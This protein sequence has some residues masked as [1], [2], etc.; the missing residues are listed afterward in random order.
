MSYLSVLTLSQAK[1][2]LRVDDDLNEDDADITNMINAAFSYLE[3]QT[4]HM[5]I[6]REKTYPLSGKDCLTIHDHPVN[7][8]SKGIDKDDADVAITAD[9]YTIYTKTLHKII[10]VHDSDV[11]QLV[12]NV[13]Y[14]DPN[15]IPRELVD[16]GKAIIK[17][18]YYNK[19]AETIDEVLTPVIRAMIDSNRRFLI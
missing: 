16:A 5:F 18:L 6:V 8:V 14:A 1:V 13:G 3:K 19:E 7:S 15:N 2:Y 10:D 4:G 11:K 9:D 17:G 12:L